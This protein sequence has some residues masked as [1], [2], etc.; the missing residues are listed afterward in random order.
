MFRRYRR[1][2]LLQKLASKQAEWQSLLI[3]E[4]KYENSYYTDRAIKAHCEYVELSEK[5]KQF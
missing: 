1:N 3:A 2:R 5:L 4:K